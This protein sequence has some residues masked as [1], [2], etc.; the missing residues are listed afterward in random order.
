MNEY[1]VTKRDLDEDRDHMW[2]AIARCLTDLRKEYLLILNT[3]GCKNCPAENKKGDK[4]M[5]KVKT[6]IEKLWL[7]ADKL[8]NKELLDITKELEKYVEKTESFTEELEGLK[9][10]INTLKERVDKRG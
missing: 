6:L 10:K 7:I 8:D 1:F 9:K 5:S 2:S 3:L 4:R